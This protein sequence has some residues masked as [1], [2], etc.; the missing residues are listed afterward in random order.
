[1]PVLFSRVDEETEAMAKR[2]ADEDQR[3]VSSEI[4]WLIRQEWARRYS[5]PNPLISVADAMLAGK[6]IGDGK[7]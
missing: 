6:E 4:A 1:M 3:S 7:E 5:R 2:L